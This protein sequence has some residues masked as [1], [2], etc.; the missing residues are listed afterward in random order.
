M[1]VRDAY[2]KLAATQINRAAALHKFCAS[3]SGSPPSRAKH[4]VLVALQ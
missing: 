2:T 1:V 3:L 4:A